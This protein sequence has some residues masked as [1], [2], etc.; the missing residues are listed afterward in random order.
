MRSDC[1]CLASGCTR[2]RRWSTARAAA[3]MP[4]SSAGGSSSPT[5]QACP[6]PSLFLV[7][8]SRPLARPPPP[9]APARRGHRCAAR[10]A[11]GAGAGPASGP[12]HARGAGCATPG[13][14]AAARLA[15]AAPYR[16]RLADVAVHFTQGEIDEGEVRPPEAGPY[17]GTAGLS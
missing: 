11:G 12:S 8:C 6:A 2:S 1:S 17:G 9:P 15:R 4:R 7:L 3:A 14:E 16:V 10:P 5:L 13:A